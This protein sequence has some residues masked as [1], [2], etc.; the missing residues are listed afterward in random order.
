[1]NIIKTQL[2]L[3]RLIDNSDSVRWALLVAVTIVFTILLYPNLVIKKYSYKLGDVVTRD[4]KAAK[5]FLIE[6]KDATEAGRKQAVENVLTVYDHDVNISTKTSLK[7]KKAFDD[8]RAML[9]T[10]KSI[11]SLKKTETSSS[12]NEEQKLIVHNLIWQKKADF[13]EKIGISVNDADY[14]ILEL[15]AFSDDISKFI[16]S[17]LKE[18]FDNGV[19]A[20]KEMLLKE[21]DR[22]IILS[23]IK[24]K[25]EMLVYNL[26]H[27]YGLDQAKTMVKIIGNPILQNKTPDLR[28]LI[29][30]FAQRLIQPNITLN[31][32]ETEKRKKEAYSEV[33]PIFYKIKAG[34]ML[35]REGERVTKDQLLKL[36][37]YQEG[38]KNEKVLTN[39][40]GSALF[41]LCI[42]M[43]IYALCIHNRPNLNNTKNL[44]FLAS[45]LITFFFISSIS[46]S[47]ADSVS[48]YT[49][50]SIS[51]DSITYGIP[52]A[53]GAM[54][55]CLFLG[56]ELAIP[57]AML[58]AI[59]TAII[60]KN[61]FEI[62]IYF[63]LNSL[64]AAYWMQN[65][66]ER[67]VFIKAGLKLGLL[68]VILVT[69]IDVYIGGSTIFT[70]MWDWGFAFLGG[71]G[72]GIVT[73][74]IAPLVEIA[75]DFT[76]D[77][78]LL[79][80]ANL[81]QPILRRLMLEAPGTYHHSVIVGTMVEAAAS[82]IGANPSLAK[83]CGYFHDIGKIKK[84][85]YFIENQAD[86]VNRH[87][88][89]A[90]S[91]SSLI[92]IAHIKDGVEIAKQNK[93]GHAIIETIRQSHGTSLIRF[94]YEKA[95]QLKGENGVNMDDFR[96]PGP[97]PQTREAGLV[98][99]AD[100]VEAASRTLSNPTP[101]RI[102]GLV[103]NL[104]NRIFSD[105]QLDNCEL[106]LKDL[107]NIA[108]SFNKILNGIYHHRIEY[109]EKQFLTNGKQLLTNG[110]GKNGSVDR[111]Q[112]KEIQDIDDNNSTKNQRHLKRL[113]LS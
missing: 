74:G 25:N 24:T 40:I 104:I 65:C 29:V 108:K 61:R 84:P 31:R 62:F 86:G 95:T 47:L 33:K 77:I 14:K 37:I 20:N 34:E 32:S 7:T 90:P 72:A 100:A 58:I 5:N 70:L 44:L 93:L 89:L 69:V 43:T 92:L 28:N 101:T 11:D 67:K 53:A 57:I 56:I 81:D 13:E 87:D 46:E 97:R 52:L 109:P 78:K 102:K 106:T 79:E 63:L 85:L 12:E 64:M 91:M 113:G 76:T 68:N 16:S 26:K 42:L 30:D 98:M 19:V 10:I 21:T 111:Q 15:E 110:M 55:T 82:E 36:K 50:F 99:L 22:G 105:G 71:I 51:A 6:D 60:F 23:D 59:G 8:L 54:T 41:I 66:R 107:H 73:A 45:V 35:L 18:I 94:F 112:A 38:V 4:I 96:Y 3:N 27:F 17:I 48:R 80:L 88:K 2:S 1:M 103:Q 49:P 9:E 39:C 75:F 83:V